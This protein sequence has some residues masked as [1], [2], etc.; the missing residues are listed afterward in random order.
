MSF[1]RVFSTRQ[2]RIKPTDISRL[3]ISPSKYYV[4]PRTFTSTHARGLDNPPQLSESVVNAV[5]GTKAWDALEQNLE[6][7]QVFLETLQVL[8]DEG[9]YVETVL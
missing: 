1:I 7:Q 3:S 9:M 6:L 4:R 2:L 8:K 5:R